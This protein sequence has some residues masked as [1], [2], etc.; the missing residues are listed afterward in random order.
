[1]LLRNHN[2][3]KGNQLQERSS[4]STSTIVIKTKTI[5]TT[6]PTT[7][8]NYVCHHHQRSRSI[9]PSCIDCNRFDTTSIDQPESVRSHPVRSILKPIESTQCTRYYPSHSVRS[10]ATTVDRKVGYY[11]ITSSIVT[12]GCVRQPKIQ[13]ATTHIDQLLGQAPTSI[14]DLVSC[15]LFV[16]TGESLC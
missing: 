10:T 12:I 4:P 6:A 3:T 15:S 9:A 5:V 8:I 2:N 7:N 13:G 11:Y 16:N 14:F 1:V